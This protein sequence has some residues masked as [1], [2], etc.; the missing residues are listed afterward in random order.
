MQAG[1]RQ[2]HLKEPVDWKAGESIV[3]ASSSYDMNEFDECVI[4][5]VSLDKMSVVG[6]YLPIFLFS[7]S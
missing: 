7:S 5:S 3:I 6:K 4:E 1:D 2:I